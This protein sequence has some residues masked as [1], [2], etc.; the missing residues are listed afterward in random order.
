MVVRR[1]LLCLAQ[2]LFCTIALAQ[3]SKIDSLKK[4]L[5]ALKDTA[6]IDCFNQLSREY[7]ESDKKDSAE[8]YATLAYVE[9]K[10]SDY[11]HGIAVFFSLQSQMAK[12]FDDDFKRSEVLG[13]ES[14]QWYERTPNKEGIDNL[15]FYLIYTVFAQSRF[16]EAIGYARKRYALAKQSGNQEVM[17]DALSFMFA[18]YRQSGD[19][20]KSFLF[21]QMVYNLALKTKNKIRIT[22][23]LYGMAQL[24]ELIEDYPNALI[25]FHKVLQMD[26]AE[27]RS[28]RIATDNDIWFKMEFTEIFSHLHQFDSAWHYYNLFKPAPNKAVYWRVWWISTGEC[29][30]LQKD[31][32]HALQNFRLGLAEHKKLNDRNEVMRTLLDLGKTWL[33]LNKDPEAL[34]YGREGLDMALQTK[35]KQFIRDGYLILSTVYDRLHQTD[36]ANFYFRQFITMKDEVLNDQVKG[37]FTAYNYEQK[38]ALINKEK[39]IQ[40]AGLEKESFIKKVLI[41]GVIFL[42]LFGLI[43]FRNIM[44]KRKNERQMLEHKITL[45]K[46]ENDKTKAEF[47]QQAAELEM[48]ALRAQMNPHFIFNSLN[49]INRFI[50]QNNK[51]QASLYLTKFSKL[52]RLILQNSQTAF[53]SLDNELEAL[54]LYLELEAL[55]FDHHFVYTVNVEENIDPSVL[56]ISPLLI[57]PYAENAIWHGLMH[58]PEKGHLHITLIMQEEVLLCKITDDGVGRK[59]AADLK[60]KNTFIHN[61]LGMKITAERITLLH[62]GKL[63][64]SYVT[65]NDLILPDGS[66]GGTEVILKIPVHYD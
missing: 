29:Y 36:S 39:Q 51:L 49:S 25:Y 56:K 5:P 17:L 45:Q 28:N 14:L 26:D 30:L 50:L 12:H 44:L 53:V 9:A 54:Q 38:L 8:H 60:S 55:R 61:S 18:V 19:Y 52:V 64:N 7:I 22:G 62:Q 16:D 57:Q 23:T 10:Q 59:K 27:T 2:Y 11:I 20:E 65:I 21:A 66:A 40:Q 15:Y 41:G 43:V 58:K 34:Q 13:K 3:K 47:Q 35:A 31:Y 6:R 33:A 1:I 63:L 32:N 37:K 46:L 42:F 48:Q 4:I 24:Y